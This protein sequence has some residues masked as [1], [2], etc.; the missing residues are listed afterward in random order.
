KFNE[1]IA[2]EGAYPVAWFGKGEALREME[3]YQSAANAYSQAIDRDPSA[4]AAYNGRGECFLELQQV[5]LAANDFNNALERAPSDPKVLSN[6]GHIMVNYSRGDATAIS[7]AIRRLDDAIAGNPEDARAYRDRGFAKA[8]LREFDK[9]EADLQNA[10]EIDP[11]DHENFA[12]L[13]NVYLFQDDYA[14][15]VDALTKAIDA[16]KPEKRGDP[17]VFVTGYTLRADA[18]LKLAEKE[19]DA[20]KA[21]ALLKA[22]VADADL[23]VEKFEGRQP[24]EGRAYFRKGR[25][26]RMLKQYSDAV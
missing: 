10:A 4:A 14:K 22:V 23:I 3:D 24:E 11:A 25:A 5:D 9:A 13:A 20:E 21:E 12:V 2:I 18:R 8:M 15:S 26:L 7:T 16:Y 17:E 19:K 1:A 6:I